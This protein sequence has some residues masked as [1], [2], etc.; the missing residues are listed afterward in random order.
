MDVPP[1]DPVAALS[2]LLGSL[3]DGSTAQPSYATAAHALSLVEELAAHLRTLTRTASCGAEPAA[4]AVSI[5]P[6][7]DSQQT[8]S[9]SDSDNYASSH[10]KS[11]PSA[12]SRARMRRQQQQQ[13]QA[14]QAQAQPQPQHETQT[15]PW[16]QQWQQWQWQWREHRPCLPLPGVIEAQEHHF[17]QSLWNGQWLVVPVA[18]PL[19]TG[20][21]APGT[22]ELVVL[23][24]PVPQPKPEDF[25]HAMWSGEWRMVPLSYSQG[26]P[27]PPQYGVAANGAMDPA[28]GVPATERARYLPF[29]LRVQ[30]CMRVYRWQRM[31][32]IWTEWMRSSGTQADSSLA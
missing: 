17:R 22:P 21:S 15:E 2:A 16:Q 32:R 26:Q 1:L 25:R 12:R 27:L 4:T 30:R 5:I 10:S 6:A 29:R 3:R 19:T 24:A 11:R 8:T 13:Q 7:C 9:E 18:P 23:E 28:L 20:I 14:Q 31:Q